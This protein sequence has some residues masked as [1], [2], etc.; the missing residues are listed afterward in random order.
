MTVVEEVD[1]SQW[2]Q[3]ATAAHEA[4]FTFLDLLAGIDRIDTRELLLRV[5]NPSGGD[6]RTLVTRLSATDP[7]VASLGNLWSGA[8][9]QEREIGEMFGVMF[10][11][12]PDPRPLLTRDLAG[13]PALLKSTPLSERVTTPWPG[14]LDAPERRRRRPQLP[15]GVRSEWVETADDVEEVGGA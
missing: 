14:A 1:A 5:V 13:E 3:Q 15:P 11:G 9:W 2:L 4:G 10:E 7:R 8:A 12:H 6:T